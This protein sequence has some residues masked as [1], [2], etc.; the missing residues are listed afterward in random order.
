MNH[1][2]TP[3]PAEKPRWFQ[4]SNDQW[5]REWDDQDLRQFDTLQDLFIEAGRPDLAERYAAKAETVN[6]EALLNRMAA[7]VAKLTTP[8]LSTC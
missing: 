3:Q 8:K 7:R 2:D 5:D 6:P 1:K 4:D